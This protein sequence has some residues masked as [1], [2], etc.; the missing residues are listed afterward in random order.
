VEERKR[1]EGFT[2][3]VGG[4]FCAGIGS[5][6]TKAGTDSPNWSV[7]FEGEGDERG[8]SAFPFLPPP[9]RSRAKSTHEKVTEQN[10]ASTASSSPASQQPAPN[11]SPPSSPSSPA[12][13]TPDSRPFSI[14]TG[15]LMR[16]GRQL[17]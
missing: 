5:E 12:P 3:A 6:A 16:S 7:P 2:G 11:P 13:P 9:G 4:L 14:R 8:A 10:T 15:C 17:G 1:W